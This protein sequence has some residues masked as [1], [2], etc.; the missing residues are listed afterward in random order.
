MFKKYVKLNVKLI[1]IKQF[2]REFRLGWHTHITVII[3]EIINGACLLEKK[4]KTWINWVMT[5]I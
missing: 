1:N 3:K 5:M 4:R 2:K